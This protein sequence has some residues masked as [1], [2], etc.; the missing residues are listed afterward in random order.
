M[1]ERTAAALARTV[2]AAVRRVAPDGDL[3][4]AFV[5]T[6]DPAAFEALVRRHG[7]LVLVACRAVLS[8]PAD[9]DDACQAAFVVLHRKAHTVRDPRTLGGW[10]F[11]VAR[12]AA[13]E[14]KAASARRR[15]REP[16]AARPEPLPAPDLSW[17]E[18]CAILHEELDRL[19]PRYRLPL[20][21]CYLEGK[22]R[23]EAAAELGSTADAVR[24]RVNRGRER[25]RKRLD[26]RGVT[27]SAALL[28]AV[29]VPF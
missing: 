23:D 3:L 4:T 25:L 17:R 6:K 18:A 28:A 9:A 21:L 14:V 12:R 10:L 22:T 5:R 8:D 11:R 19:P 20:L 13:L 26:R 16:G 27:L 7:P 15:D 29:A 24:G 1:P 2:R